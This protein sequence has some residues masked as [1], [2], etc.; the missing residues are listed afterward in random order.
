MELLVGREVMDNEEIKTE[1]VNKIVLAMWDFIGE[2]NGKKLQAVMYAALAGYEMKPTQTSLVVYDEDNAMKYLE[3]F[4]IDKKIKGCT[5]RTLKYYKTQLQFIF[6][7]IGI[8]PMNIQTD[9]IRLYIANR[10]IKD[11]ISDVTVNNEIRVLS[12]FY[13]WMQSEEYRLKNPMKRISQIRLYKKKKD[14]YTDIEIEKMRGALETAR[15]KAMFEMLLSTWCRVSELAQIKL[16]EINGNE[17]LLHGKGKK[18][19]TAYLNAK[20]LLAIQNYMNERKDDSPYLF[21]RMITIADSRKKGIPT[22][23]L[24]FYYRIPDMLVTDE[25]ISTSTIEAR[26]RVLGRRLNIFA[27]PHKFRRTGATMALRA[28]MPIEQVSKILGH[29][30]IKTTQIYLDIKETDI[31]ASHER[32]V[33]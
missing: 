6:E 14:A 30:D 32:Y 33:R 19:R 21:P 5:D 18:D 24:K 11:K 25:H 17:V 22:K 1:F 8:E 16:N 2:V 9:H 12:S 20:A 29:E 3:K 26:V 31:K 27:H 4:L 23:E 15:D 10:Q 28:G 7:K 13:E